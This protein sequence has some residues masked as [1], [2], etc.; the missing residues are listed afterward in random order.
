MSALTREAHAQIAS[1]YLGQC[2]PV[3]PNSWLTVLQRSHW[4]RD[5][6]LV[7]SQPVLAGASS[8]NSRLE[9]KTCLRVLC[10]KAEIQH[11]QRI[12]RRKVFLKRCFKEQE[13]KREIVLVFSM[14]RSIFGKILASLFKAEEENKSRGIK[15]DILLWEKKETLTWNE[16]VFSLLT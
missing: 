7:T 5:I 11:C 8:S 13:K 14:E 3:N 6:K 16:N 12:L 10:R 15:L 1:H 2:L 9:G 4:L